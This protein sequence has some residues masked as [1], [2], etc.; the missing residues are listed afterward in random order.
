MKRLPILCIDFDGVIHSYTSGWKGIDQIPDPPVP[1][2]IYALQVYTGYFDVHIYSSRSKEQS[3]IDA[4]VKWL[5][6]SGFEPQYLS[7]ISFPSQKPPAFLTIDDRA[8]CFMG[9]FPKPKDLLAFKPWFKREEELMIQIKEVAEKM[10]KFKRLEIA[11]GL[12]NQLWEYLVK[13]KKQDELK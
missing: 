2:A 6:K 9:N 13:N 7:K 3:G 1:G 10:D 11:S 5:M 12:K 4:M 8:I